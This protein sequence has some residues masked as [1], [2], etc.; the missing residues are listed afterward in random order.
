MQPFISQFLCDFSPG[1][2]PPNTINKRV[3]FSKIISINHTKFSSEYNPYSWIVCLSH[4]SQQYNKY[5]QGEKLHN[6]VA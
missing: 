5:D 6:K 2:N 4:W 1:N 3:F